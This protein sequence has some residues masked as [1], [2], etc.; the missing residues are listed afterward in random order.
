MQYLLDTRA[1]LWFINGDAQLSDNART[2]I[3]NPINERYVSI[4][5]F[6]EMAIKLK[7]GKLELDMSFKELYQEMDR[8][9]F[10]LLPITVAHTEKTVA[11]DLHH[12]DPFDRMLI[13]QAMID[14]LIII[15][16]DSQ[17]HHYEVKQICKHNLLTLEG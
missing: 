14:K 1:F 2:L 5:S 11:L 9:G 10:N 8:N 17:F 15:T 4:A 13:C 16:A 6:W 3:E 7:L 12:R